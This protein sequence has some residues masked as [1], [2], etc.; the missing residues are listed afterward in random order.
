[1]TAPNMSR[2]RTEYGLWS[3]NRIDGH[4]SQDCLPFVGVVGVCDRCGTDL[5]GRQIRWCSAA[6][7][8]WY[9]TNHTWQTARHHALKRDE[10]RCTRCGNDAAVLEVDHIIERRGMPMSQHS[11][12]HHLEN[13]R[14]LCHNCHRTRHEWDRA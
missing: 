5:T 12:L 13:L 7:S 10:R 4:V 3:A 8:D 6:C 1:M 9:F 11:C 2:V 14:T